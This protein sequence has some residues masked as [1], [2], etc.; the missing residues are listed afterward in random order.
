MANF[1]FGFD[2]PSSA[3]AKGGAD[4]AAP[5][6]L[7]ARADM[8]LS[9]DS[10][11]LPAPASAM[12][13]G[14]QEH[15]QGGDEGPQDSHFPAVVVPCPDAVSV[16]LQEPGAVYRAAYTDILFSRSATSAPLLPLRKI[17]LDQHPDHVNS[18]AIPSNL[19]IV[20]STYGGGYKTWE[21]SVDL[22]QYLIHHHT[23]HQTQQAQGQ[24]Q[25]A[26]SLL[27]L[28]CGHGLPGIAALRY[29]G[30]RRA[31]FNDLNSE[32]LRDTT[33]PNVALNG[34]A[35][36]SGGGVAATVQCLG[37]HWNS[38][39]TTLGQQTFD[40]VLSAETAYSEV[41]VKILMQML[42]RHLARGPS[43]T[44]G[45]AYLATKRFYFGLSGGTACI[46]AEAAAC[47]LSC[48]VVHS[49][50]DGASNIRDI[51]LLEHMGAGL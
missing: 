20:P 6:P 41:N 31:I 26:P 14:A 18:V 30:Y 46:E 44:H 19:D 43:G 13:R 47:G 4:V 1:S 29:L 28:G 21:C 16:Q 23:Q 25:A 39:S 27:E 15:G 49:I 22:A 36:A 37:G 34:V 45:K 8:E 7:D 38:V 10:A 50:E 40:L 11:H 32:V 17:D 51:C 24:A 9:H 33:W 35:S 5:T 48:I 3:G 12:H 42:R 2:L